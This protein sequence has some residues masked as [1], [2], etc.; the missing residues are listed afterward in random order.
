MYFTW[1]PVET[2]A[3]EFFSQRAG[4]REAGT[5]SSWRFTGRDVELIEAQ[6]WLR[7]GSMCKRSKCALF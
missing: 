4:V 1:L 7:A 2:E 5:V 3:L 6:H